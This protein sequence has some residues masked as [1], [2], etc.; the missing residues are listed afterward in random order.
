M[1][2][3]TAFFTGFILTANI[4]FPIV[5]GVKETKIK[6][7]YQPL[8]SFFLNINETQPPKYLIK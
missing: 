6:I 2:T 7:L 5:S 4:Q 1:F 8:D 3:Y